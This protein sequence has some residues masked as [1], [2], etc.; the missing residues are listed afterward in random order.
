MPRIE[1]NPTTLFRD[2]VDAKE[3]A[4]QSQDGKPEP[5]TNQCT[6]CTGPKCAG[7]CVQKCMPNPPRPC[8]QK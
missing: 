1:L 5:I 4:Q 3:F 7:P 6:S 2:M 8:R